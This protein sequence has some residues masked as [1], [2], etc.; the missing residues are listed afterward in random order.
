M[1][2]LNIYTVSNIQASQV[3]FVRKCCRLN[4]QVH[5]HVLWGCICVCGRMRVR[6]LYN[7]VSCVSCTRA[8]QCLLCT[9]AH[10]GAP[11]GSKCVHDSCSHHKPVPRDRSLVPARACD[12]PWSLASD[13]HLALCRRLGHLA[14]S[15]DRLHVLVRLRERQRLLVLG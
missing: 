3:S 15:R 2:W 13:C 10:I 4:G 5:S 9:V 6:M 14:C 8:S 7:D 1:Y 12:E 11:I